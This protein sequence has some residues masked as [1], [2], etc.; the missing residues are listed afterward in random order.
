MRWLDHWRKWVG[1]KKSIPESELREA[2]P[3]GR[4]SIPKGVRPP[5]TR[6]MSRDLSTP[7]HNRSRKLCHLL[8]RSSPIAKRGV[9]NLC[10]FITSEGFEPRATCQDEQHRARLQ[11]WL[12]EWWRVNRWD[13]SLARRYRTLSV[14]GEWFI[15]RTP[16][17][18]KGISLLKFL[19]PERVSDVEVDELDAERFCRVKFSPALEFEIDGQRGRREVLDVA[20]EDNPDGDVLY[21]QLNAVTGQTRGFS[22][23]LVI[24]DWLDQLETVILTEVERVQF[25]RAYVW[26]VALTGEGEE[27]VIS[28]TARIQ[29]AGP[30]NPGSV[31][32]HNASETWEAKAPELHLQD[33]V[34]FI[35]F[36]MHLVFGGIYMP[37]HFYATGGD[38]NKATSANMGTPIFSVARDRKMDLTE[39]FRLAISL[40]LRLARQMGVF[41]LDGMDTAECFDFELQSKDPDRSA[42]DV[43]GEMLSKY[44]EA[45][46]L[47]RE[48]GWISKVEAAQAFRMA[49]NGM[50]LGDFPGVDMDSLE[51]AEAAA[52]SALDAQ[53]STLG[54]QFPLRVVPPRQSLS[55]SESEGDEKKKLITDL[56]AITRIQA[57]ETVRNA[58]DA[59]TFAERMAREVST[60]L[61]AGQPAG[62]P[63]SEAHVESVLRRFRPRFKD[64]M[65]RV[66]LVG[67]VDSGRQFAA[68]ALGLDDTPSGAKGDR[69]LYWRVLNTTVKEPPEGTDRSAGGRRRSLGREAQYSLAHWAGQDFEEAILEQMREAKAQGHSLEKFTGSLMDGKLAEVTGRRVM[70]N[71]AYAEHR[72]QKYAEELIYQD[73]AEANDGLEVKF[74]KVGSKFCR[75]CT[76]LSGSS[77]DVGDQAERKKYRVPQHKGCRCGWFPVP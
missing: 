29:E 47:G 45:L 65:P 63:I 69:S 18:A 39:F 37:E 36:L 70:S 44:G 35:K 61:L 19:K 24:A 31:L 5:I 32:V 49:A 26:D 9:E 72:A 21:F 56:V 20:D 71:I 50:G 62:A 75:H 22:D 38:V 11:Q 12:D 15:W 8:Y 14:E 66:G 17:N 13:R 55:E 23:L 58:S 68:R 10:S 2:K 34:A 73:V 46:K 4:S 6:D 28:A 67:A 51:Q 16:P 43:F 54:Q 59:R 3:S 76:H 42:Y 52:R 25:Q 40:D 1:E 57:E 60:E 30:P 41:A 74:V 53:R 64:G 27:S 48:M 77:F 33:S 7:N